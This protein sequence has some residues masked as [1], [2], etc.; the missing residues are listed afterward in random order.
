MFCF[1]RRKTKGTNLVKCQDP[2]VLIGNDCHKLI[3]SFLDEGT[4]AICEF[5]SVRWYNVSREMYRDLNVQ[6]PRGLAIDKFENCTITLLKWLKRHR[7]HYVCRPTYEFIIGDSHTFSWMR[8]EGMDCWRVYKGAATCGDIV[9]LNNIAK[10]Y[11]IC[12]YRNILKPPVKHHQLEVIKWLFHRY[13]LNES[14][15]SLAAGYGCI[16]IL[17][18][19]AETGMRSPVAWFASAFI[20]GQMQVIGWAIERKM[21]LKSI[22][23]RYIFWGGITVEKL[24]WAYANDCGRPPRELITKYIQ[25]NYID[26]ITRWFCDR[27]FV[28]SDESYY[29]Q[30]LINNNVHSMVI[31][32][33]QSPI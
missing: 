19:V 2:T 17:D 30:K 4:R 3:Y 7:F 1:G 29:D 32:I 31:G 21:I 8:S 27:G 5:V 22:V 13:G 24:D 33:I 12:S 20:T 10:W 9:M 14:V 26:E 18:F 6:P 11:N 15:W 28:S 16:S 23:Y 25:N